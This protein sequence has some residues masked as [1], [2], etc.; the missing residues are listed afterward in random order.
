MTAACRINQPGRGNSTW[1][2][3]RF[4]ILRSQERRGQAPDGVDQGKPQK[5]EHPPSHGQKLP[6]FF[7][8][9]TSYENSY[10]P[11]VVSYQ[12]KKKARVDRDNPHVDI[13]VK[14]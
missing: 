8:G 12:P 9:L 6:A 14:R 11:S 7:H 10:Q 13:M 3:Q 1:G 5:M 2:S 4:I